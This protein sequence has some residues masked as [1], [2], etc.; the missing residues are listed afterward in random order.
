MTTDLPIQTIETANYQFGYL[1]QHA[2]NSSH[3]PIVMVH[4]YPGRPQDFRFLF[5]HLADFHCI[6]YL[7]HHMTLNPTFHCV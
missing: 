2:D 3:P 7:K 1:E 6:V 5:P 4:G